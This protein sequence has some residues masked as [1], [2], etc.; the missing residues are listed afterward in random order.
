[1]LFNLA[2]GWRMRL[3]HHLGSPGFI[4]RLLAIVLLPARCWHITFLPGLA[5]PQ[6]V[7]HSRGVFGDHPKSQGAGPPLPSYPQNPALALLPTVPALLLVLFLDSCC[8]SS[9]VPLLWS[10]GR[11]EL[12]LQGNSTVYHQSHHPTDR[13]LHHTSLP[14]LPC[15]TRISFRLWRQVAL[16]GPQVQ[17]VKIGRPPKWSHFAGGPVNNEPPSWKQIA[18]SCCYRKQ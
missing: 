13:L 17:F 1:M 14:P 7:P 15:K 9:L 3:Q 8:G 6:K 5:L 18:P 2:L 4:R 16:V 12:D 11:S 10:R